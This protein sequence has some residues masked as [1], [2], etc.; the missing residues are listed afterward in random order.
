M[1]IDHIVEELD[2]LVAQVCTFNI[3]VKLLF[4]PLIVT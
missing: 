2:K 4:V 3:L 1:A